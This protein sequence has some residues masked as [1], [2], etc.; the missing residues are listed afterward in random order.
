ME[1]WWL[2]KLKRL[3][4]VRRGLRTKLR[5]RIGSTLTPLVFGCES[6]TNTLLGEG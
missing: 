5:K 6:T 3:M 2:V 4:L 1:Q